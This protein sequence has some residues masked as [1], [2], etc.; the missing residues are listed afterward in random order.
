MS[1][2]LFYPFND[3][4]EKTQLEDLML[5]VGGVP[6]PAGHAFPVITGGIYRDDGTFPA[7]LDVVQDDDE[8]YV[9]GHGGEGQKVMGDVNKKFYDQ[10]AIFNMLK[11]AGLQS[12]KN[13]KL[14]IYACESGLGQEKGAGAKLGAKIASALKTNKYACSENVWGFTKKVAMRQHKGSLCVLMGDKWQSIEHHP[15]TLVKTPPSH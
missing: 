7:S 2:Y 14:I 6:V 1:K 8:V 3:G 5:G 13:C 12:N 15:Y 11:A 9:I 10:T 4:T